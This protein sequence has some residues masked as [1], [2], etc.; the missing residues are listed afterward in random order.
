MLIHIA[1]VD[2]EERRPWKT[3]SHLREWQA[4]L[5]PRSEW[6]FGSNGFACVDCCISFECRIERS[7]R[8]GHTP[9]LLGWRTEILFAERELKPPVRL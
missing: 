8:G 5:S 3:S 7:N 4:L 2:V 6:R 1:T 9:E